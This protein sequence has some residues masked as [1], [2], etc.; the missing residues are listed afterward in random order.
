MNS[1]GSGVAV[2]RGSIRGG[3]ALSNGA[4][5]G[6]LP[7]A[8]LLLWF[9]KADLAQLRVSPPGGQ[10]GVVALYVLALGVA[11]ERGQ[12]ALQIGATA[13][14]VGTHVNDILTRFRE[15]ANGAQPLLL[16]LVRACFCFFNGEWFSHIHSVCIG[17]VKRQSARSAGRLRSGAAASTP[18]C[19]R[20]RPLWSPR[21]NL[22]RLHRSLASVGNNLNQ[23]ARATNAEGFVPVELRDEL[24]HTIAAVRR[25]AEQIDEVVDQLGVRA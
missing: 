16:E 3:V 17:S 8:L 6:A 25:T 1:S 21:R 22:F 5:S 20:W 7:N 14:R 24:R 10:R 2:C 23:I 15:A 19:P 18:S 9:I 12:F 4:A 11:Q 13:V